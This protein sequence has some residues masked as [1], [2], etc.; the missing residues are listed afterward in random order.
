MSDEEE[1][2]A[3]MKLVTPGGLDVLDDKERERVM[4]TADPQLERAM[5]VLKGIKLFSQ[6]APLDEK[7]TPKVGK[8]AAKGS[9]ALKR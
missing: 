1:G 6:R 9:E 4:K 8:Y 3:R 2:I 7:G 5:D